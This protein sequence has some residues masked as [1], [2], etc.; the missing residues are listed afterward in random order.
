MTLLELAVLV[1]LAAV[2]GGSFLFIRV[3]VP[4]LGPAPLVLARV[5]I[6]GALLALLAVARRQSPWGGIRRHRRALLVLGLTNAA[7]P[8][9]LIAAA[10]LHI[11][12]SLA[13]VLNA[14][15]PLATALLGAAWTG[16]RIGAK[17]GAGLLLGVA[18]VAVLVGWSALPSSLATWASVAALL[19]ATVSYAFAGLWARHRLAGVPSPTLALGQQVAAVAWLA[20][21]G[22]ATLPARLPSS[23]ALG[24]LLALAVVSTAAAYLLWFWLLARVGPTRTASVTYLIPVFGAT[25]GA[26]FLGERFSGGMLAGLA[27][28]LGSVVLVNDLRLPGRRR[29]VAETKAPERRAA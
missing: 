21:P 16:E 3:A 2:W 23:S 20:I 9:S 4:E 5:A 8:F 22:A 15:V 19:G 14:T 18:G 29:E 26:L 13:S 24:A 6:A 28:I 17:R 27:A 7:L 11:T 12:A 1:L 10:E 25:W